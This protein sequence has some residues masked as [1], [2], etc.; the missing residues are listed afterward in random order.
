[1]A[2]KV[3]KLTFSSDERLIHLVK[4]GHHDTHNLLPGCGRDNF[5]GISTFPAPPLM[6]YFPLFFT[7]FPRVFRAAR[8]CQA[9]K[10][11]M[12]E[13]GQG[14]ME[15]SFFFAASNLS[16]TGPPWLK[17]MRRL[18]PRLRIK[19]HGWKNVSLSMERER[20]RERVEAFCRASWPHI[21][22]FK[23]KAVR[24]RSHTRR[25]TFPPGRSRVRVAFSAIYSGELSMMQRCHLSLLRY[26][27]QICVFG[28]EVCACSN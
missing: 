25:V 28:T 10:V 9:G 27:V 12:T 16:G 23:M 6:L 17:F 11:F 19:E 21:R 2:C 13:R 8:T 18:Y 22:Y 1:M 5:P 4:V 3:L 14:R 15:N 20:E 26:F 24:V 7:L